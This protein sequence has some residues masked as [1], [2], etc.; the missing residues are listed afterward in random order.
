MQKAM[1][2]DIRRNSLA[3]GPGIRTT[4][5]FKGCGMRCEWCHNPES[6]LAE[7][8]ILFY[9]E[10]C[11]GCGRCKGITAKD[12][13][14]HCLYGA[15]EICG[16]EYEADEL[17]EVIA[18]DKAFYENS[19][20]GVTFSGGECMLWADFLEQVLKR[21]KDNSIHTAVDTAGFVPWEQFER[22]LP[23]TDLFLYDIK[24]ADV[25]LHQKFTGVPNGL[26]LSNL[27][28]LFERGA[29]III[30][31]PVI[32]GVNADEQEMRKI[33]DVLS[34]YR[35]AG[36]ELLPYHKMGEHKFD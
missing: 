7:P 17:F 36:V 32:P 15:M 29:N 30:R 21:C 13:D 1:I 25:R 10:K 20:G 34:G 2:F 16:R 35:L 33:A 9:R 28:K 22:V 3:D 24:T 14:F 5:F 23:Y 8:Q 31:I 4:V 11:V 19:G 6:Q 12:A 18:E 26:I 27:K